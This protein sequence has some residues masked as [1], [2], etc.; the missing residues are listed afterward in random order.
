MTLADLAAAIERLP[1]GAALSLPVAELRELV[2]D[3]AEAHGDGDGPI[4][5][6]SPSF[7][8]PLMDLSV[9]DIMVATGKARS[10]VIGWMREL[11][12]LGAYRFGREW[13][14]PRAAWDEFLARRRAGTSVPVT[15]E[16]RRRKADLGGWRRHVRP[17]GP[18]G[19]TD[20]R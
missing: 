11:R 17:G 13:R 5:N 2:R 9:A 6:G 8:E 4:P 10:T 19:R 15:S 14:I 1:D 16:R 18:D 3:A 7:D 12:D 20:G